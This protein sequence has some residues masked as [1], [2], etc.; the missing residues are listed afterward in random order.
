[1]ENEVIVTLQKS[2]VTK[3]VKSSTSGCCGG[4]SKNNEDACCVLDEQKK[5]EGESG[6]GCNTG[7]DKSKSSCC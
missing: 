1:M 7:A 4:P 2:T 3:E 5:A 6:C